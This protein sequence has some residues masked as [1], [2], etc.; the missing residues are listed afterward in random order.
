LSK[1]KITANLILPPFLI[2][3]VRARILIAVLLVVF[4]S[5]QL[6]QRRAFLPAYFTEENILEHLGVPY[7]KQQSL[8]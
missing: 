1:F 4:N 3:I 6:K 8:G 7:P 2:I 5:A